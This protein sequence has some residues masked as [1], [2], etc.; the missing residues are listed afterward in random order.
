MVTLCSCEDKKTDATSTDISRAKEKQ[1]AKTQE[2]ASLAY[3]RSLDDLSKILA[4]VKDVETAQAAIAPLKATGL[5]IRLIKTDMEN[6]G[7]K[8]NALE[9]KLD[10]KYSSQMK[11]TLAEI[12][13]T[14]KNLR[15]S[16]PEAY[17]LIERVMI[18]IMQ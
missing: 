17:K 12:G 9:A 6:L 8:N 2:S 15:A 16:E 10:E 13:R 14:M 7:K 3:V 18:A 1:D 4:G 11:T 5:E